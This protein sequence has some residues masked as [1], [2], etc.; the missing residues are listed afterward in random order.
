[1]RS[2]P[3]ASLSFHS[4]IILSGPSRN[5]YC[6]SQETSGLLWEQTTPKSQW[7]AV[8]EVYLLL[9]FHI[10]HELASVSFHIIIQT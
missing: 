4:S 6:V 5:I 9:M 7:A 3:C 10:Y 8:T 2:F 1:M